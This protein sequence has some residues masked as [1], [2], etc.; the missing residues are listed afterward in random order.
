MGKTAYGAEYRGH[1][2]KCPTV[3]GIAPHGVK[4]IV[5][6]VDNTPLPPLEERAYVFIVP[7]S[8]SGKPWVFHT[9]HR[10]T[11]EGF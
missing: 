7:L 10:L 3:D 8:M 4:V 5:C 2:G 6:Q 1:V 11:E 9:V